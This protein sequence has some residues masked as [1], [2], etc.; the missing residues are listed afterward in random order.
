MLTFRRHLLFV[1]LLFLWFGCQEK[2]PS[3]QELTPSVTIAIDSNILDNQALKAVDSTLIDTT[4]F[5]KALEWN[6][7]GSAKQLVD[8]FMVMY[9]GYFGLSFGLDPTF[10]G[11]FNLLSVNLDQDSQPEHILM[12]GEEYNHYQLFVVKKMFDTWENFRK[13]HDE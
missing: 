12:I 6:F 5:Q 3:H 7:N 2:K 13:C 10:T 9:P 11:Y 8:E 4:W 1:T